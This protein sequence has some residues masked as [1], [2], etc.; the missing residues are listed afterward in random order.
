LHKPPNLRRTKKEHNILIQDNTQAPAAENWEQTRQA[1]WRA[2]KRARI[3]QQL[4]QVEV[5][6]RL[7]VPQSFVSKYEAGDRSL[8]LIEVLEVCRALG[9]TL[10]KLLVLFEIE[11]ANGTS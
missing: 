7:N 2:L 9:I 10:E 11:Q 4:R 3:E 5:A 1:L 8:D 6:K